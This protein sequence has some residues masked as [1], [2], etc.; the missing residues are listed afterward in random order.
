MGRYAFTLVAL[1]HVITA[2]QG[3]ELVAHRGASRDAPENTLAAFRLAFEQGA[4]AIEGDFF[5][6]Q[7]GEI[8]CLHDK[9]TKRTGDK[10]LTVADSTLAELRT[11][12]VG[13]WKDQRFKDERIPT[14]AEVM[15]IVPEG[16]KLLIEIKC[17]VEI[18]K[19]LRAALARGKLKSEQLRIIAFQADV[20]AACRTAMPRI[21]AYWLT[22]FSLNKKTKTHEPTI[23][24]ILATL[25]RIR[26]TG[27]D[28]NAHASIDEAFVRRLRERKLE[29]HVWTVDKVKTAERFKAFGVDSI[30]TNRPAGLREEL[31]L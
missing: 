13:T 1:L 8:V 10:T 3:Q 30:T 22:N 16:K 29:F 24:S 21:R 27:L 5:L 4:D 12:D 11:V 14:L 2:A 31:G 18:V 26:A 23:D 6:S 25:K 28:C 15:A 9:T 19:P 17:G 20:I 7:D